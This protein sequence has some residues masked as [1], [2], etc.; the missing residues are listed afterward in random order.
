MTEYNEFPGRTRA[1]RAVLRLLKD[2]LGA[3]TVDWVV[4]TAFLVFLGIGASFYVA[5]SVPV[6]ADKISQNMSSMTVL[7]D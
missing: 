7:P 5:T 4:L 1:R 3:I 6:V 2:E